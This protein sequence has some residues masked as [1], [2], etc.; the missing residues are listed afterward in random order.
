MTHRQESGQAVAEYSARL[1]LDANASDLGL[2]TT[3]FVAA[4]QMSVDGGA[5]W[6]MVCSSRHLGTRGAPPGPLV[7]TYR[8]DVVT[9]L[10][11]AS[12]MFRGMV[13]I[14]ASSCRIGCTVE[15]D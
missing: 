9:R 11:P 12:V 8:W 4:I 14:L 3:D 2:S 13:R 1:E 15:A 7:I 5:T 10:Q 6:R